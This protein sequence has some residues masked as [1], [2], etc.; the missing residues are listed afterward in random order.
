[1]AWGPINKFVCVLYSPT[2]SQNAQTTEIISLGRGKAP[3]RSSIA[4]LRLRL[5]FY[6][7][8][9][10]LRIKTGFHD[11]EDTRQKRKKRQDTGQKRLCQSK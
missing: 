9:P 1:M 7:M 11:Q 6:F 2:R 10:L 8:R 4:R 5:K 3:T